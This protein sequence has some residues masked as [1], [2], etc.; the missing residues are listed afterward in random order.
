V[1]TTVLLLP[2]ALAMVVLGV[3]YWIAERNSALAPSGPVEQRV[4]RR[5]RERLMRGEI[6]AEDYNR[7]VALMR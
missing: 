3:T 5:L 4:V 2:L 7:L 6:S 1:T